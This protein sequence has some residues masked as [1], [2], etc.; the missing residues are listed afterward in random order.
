MHRIVRHR[1]RHAAPGCDTIGRTLR[2]ALRVRCARSGCRTARACG[3]ATRIGFLSRFSRPVIEFVHRVLIVH[4]A[5]TAARIFFMMLA[6]RAATSAFIAPRG[7]S[8]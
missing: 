5:K 8:E 7:P 1:T 3:A 6:C 2:I 4:L